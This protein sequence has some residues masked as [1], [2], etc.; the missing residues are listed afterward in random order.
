[1]IERS[2]FLQ[3]TRWQLPCFPTGKR[4]MMTPRIPYRNRSEAGRSLAG[5]L[6]DYRARPGVLLLGVATGGVPVAD[7]VASA[8]EA[9]L[10]ALVVRKLEAPSEPG[11]TM[12]AIGPEGIQV[13]DQDLIRAL[14]ISKAAVES[15]VRRESAELERCQTLYGGLRVNWK[16]RTVIV[17]DDAAETG[18]TMLA[19]LHFA[20]KHAPHEIVAACP[21]A[22]SDALE[23]F[24]H[25]ADGSVCLAI[26][27][28]FASVTD[29]YWSFPPTTESDVVRLLER[30]RSQAN[31]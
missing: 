18:W 30:R 13:L 8:L 7:E 20:R 12:G 26:R 10:E 29:W 1:M 24:R 25:E 9:P 3:L 31:E 23:R 27:E 17:I 4:E 14:G 19:A 6:M 11:L 16:N 2:L 5:E 28:V 21:V 22:S 15:V